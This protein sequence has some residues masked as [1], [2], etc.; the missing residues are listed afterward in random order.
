MISKTATGMFLAE[1]RIF[2]NGHIEIVAPY[3]KNNNQN[4]SA[5]FLIIDKFL[6]MFC[7]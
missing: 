5:Y 7:S 6:F 1:A 4:I 3:P 2:N